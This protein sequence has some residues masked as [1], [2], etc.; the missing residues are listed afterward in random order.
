MISSL[1]NQAIWRIRRD[2]LHVAYSEPIDIGE[3]VRDIADAGT[4]EIVL[5]TDSEAIVRIRPAENLNDGAALFTLQCGGCHDDSENRIG[6]TLRGV[7]DRAIASSEGYG[8]SAALEDLRGRWTNERLDEFLA[9]P[10]SFVP[11]TTMV[12][13]GVEDPDARSQIVAYLRYSN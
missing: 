2:G 1:A 3:R 10:A 5:W 13:D 6:P 4:G 11:G 8:Y 9:D 7:F 12:I